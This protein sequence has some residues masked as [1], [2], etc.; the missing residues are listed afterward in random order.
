MQTCEFSKLLNL[1]VIFHS[2]FIG[3]SAQK[4]LS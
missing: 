4:L 1:Q 3:R 2:Q